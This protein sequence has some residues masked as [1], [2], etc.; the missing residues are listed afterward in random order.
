MGTDPETEHDKM[1]PSFVLHDAEQLCVSFAV[2]SPA[3][4]K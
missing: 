2:F 3:L 4:A 1:L